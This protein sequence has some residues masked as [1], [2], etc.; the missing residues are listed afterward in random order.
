VVWA[1][2]RFAQA[3]AAGRRAADRFVSDHLL[4]TA[5]QFA[6]REG[7]LT[8]SRLASEQQLQSGRQMRAR[9]LEVTALR[10]LARVAGAGGEMPRARALLIEAQSLA[11]KSGDQLAETEITL[12][13]A[14]L[15]LEQG[16]LA[17][18]LK[19]AREAAS[20]H[21]DRHFAVDE[22]AALAL[23][24]EALLRLG[25][26]AE[27]REAAARAQ[28]LAPENDH[29]LRLEIA[30]ALARVAATSDPDGALR[31]LE[32][33]SLEAGQIGFVPAAFEARLAR[34]EI[35][36]RKGE[37][38]AGRTELERL[39]KEAEVKGFLQV[40]RRAAA[41]AAAQPR[42]AISP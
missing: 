12:E 17:S 38:A 5:A 36:L 21:H 27:A 2:H 9:P 16:V 20:W 8:A 4:G 7:D 11:R 15:D 28:A 13:L 40:S 39:R 1:R 31:A 42:P 32:A 35:L 26:P 33:A 3:Q 29:E 25:R 30:P 41:L 37:T 14:R 34:G 10:G 6:F 22:S 19:L 24:A 18:S 23:A